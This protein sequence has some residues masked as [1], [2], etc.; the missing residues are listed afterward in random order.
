MTPDQFLHSEKA[1][2]AVAWHIL[3][4]D[5]DRYGPR[6]AASVWY[7]GQPDWTKTY[8]NP[9]VYQYVDSVI[10]LMAHYPGG[11]FTL[12]G[13]GGGPGGGPTELQFAKVPAPG[14]DDWSTDI[15]TAANHMS[16]IANAA[17]NHAQTLNGLRINR[18]SKL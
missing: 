14:K 18:G 12:P 17:H 15:H 13:A 9:P 10:A 8:G 5:Y 11:G 4:G 2:N 6:G 3:G 16:D 7:S 1:Q